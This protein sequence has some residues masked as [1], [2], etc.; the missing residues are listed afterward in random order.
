M[1]RHTI[2]AVCY[3]LLYER[4]LTIENEITQMKPK[5]RVHEQ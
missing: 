5:K 1:L 2:N 4:T 3:F